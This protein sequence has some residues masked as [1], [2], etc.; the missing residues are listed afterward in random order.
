MRHAGLI[1]VVLFQITWFACVAGGMLW[2]LGALSVM[3]GFSWKTGLLASDLMCGAVAAIVGVVL[4]TLWIYTG[5]LDFPGATVAPVWIVMLWIGVGLSLNHGLAIFRSQPV[6]GGL[7]A[8]VAAPICYLS[9]Q[10]LG[11]V[12]VPDVTLLASVA[13]AWFVVFWLGFLVLG[14]MSASPS[15]LER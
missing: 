9:G 12:I 1:N 15:T 4:D 11:A 3:L 10:A 7:L 2:G 6:F 13:A 5:V 14:R 8:A